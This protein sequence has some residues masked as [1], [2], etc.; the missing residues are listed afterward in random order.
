MANWL[1]TSPATRCSL[2]TGAAQLLLQAGP[3]PRD[4]ISGRPRPVG[5]SAQGFTGNRHQPCLIPRSSGDVRVLLFGCSS[6][7]RPPTACLPRRSVEGGTASPVNR[8]RRFNS[9]D[10]SPA[11]GSYAGG[12]S[13]APGVVD[14]GGIMP[15][16]CCIWWLQERLAGGGRRPAAIYGPVQLHLLAAWRRLQPHGEVGRF[17]RAL[18]APGQPRVCLRWGTR[19]GSFPPGM[20]LDASTDHLGAVRLPF[21]LSGP[22]QGRGR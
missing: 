16:S 2:L 15:S 14:A 12:W 17:N 10:S 20:P 13:I 21:A 18:S 9:P 1:K 3:A 7:L 11:G 19:P 22:P 6:D 8:S 5:T 4:I